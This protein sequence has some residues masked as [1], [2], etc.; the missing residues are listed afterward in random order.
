[1]IAV[2][3]V[4]HGWSRRSWIMS[5]TARLSRLTIQH[6]SPGEDFSNT[7]CMSLVREPS[8]CCL[9]SLGLVASR[10]LTSKDN[11][12]IFFSRMGSLAQ[13]PA[14]EQTMFL[15]SLAD[16]KCPLLWG[17]NNHGGTWSPLP[18]RHLRKSNSFWPVSFKL[19]LRNAS[20]LTSH[21]VPERRK[22][23]M[24]LGR[25]LSLR[26]MTLTSLTGSSR[27]VIR[28][29]SPRS[30]WNRLDRQPEVWLL[31]KVL[32]RFPTWRFRSQFPVEV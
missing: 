7:T 1:M 4:S 15:T 23:I 8:R 18:T 19:S 28:T 16:N 27:K 17:A 29:Q 25:R 14:K 30:S 26:P 6:R 31:F 21:S 24:N 12:K 22:P 5:P 2:S 20:R 13:H 3:S 11:C 10:G 9:L 32:K